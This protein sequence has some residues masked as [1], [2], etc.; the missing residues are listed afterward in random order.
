MFGANNTP[1]EV[2]APLSQYMGERM[3]KVSKIV[4][5]MKRDIKAMK[6]ALEKPECPLKAKILT[7]A[8]VVYLACPIDLIPDCI[9]VI[10]YL[11]DVV[12]V[13]GLLWAARKSIPDELWKR[14]QAEA[15]DTSKLKKTDWRALPV[16]AALWIGSVALT[17]KVGKKILFSF[18]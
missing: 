1:G 15:E 13:G 16:F 6:I 9:P 8:A 12:I 10:G 4:K 17:Y 2:P 14:C 3:Q 7:T 18:L 11:D 5:E